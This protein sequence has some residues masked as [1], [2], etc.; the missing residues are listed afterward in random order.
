MKRR[1]TITEKPPSFI[2]EKRE[3]KNIIP[4]SEWR[5]IPKCVV[6]FCADIDDR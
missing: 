3:V 4:P 1:N 5:N 2:E 6:D